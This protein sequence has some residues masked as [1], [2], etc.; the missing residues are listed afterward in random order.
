M[1]E[2]AALTVSLFLHHSLRLAL[3][4]AVALVAMGGCTSNPGGPS[5]GYYSVTSAS[6]EFYKYGP[7]Q[8]F[9]PDLL[10]KKGERL[11]ML[12]RQWGFSRVMMSNG[13]AGYVASE[14]I[15]P[16]IVSAASVRTASGSRR[17]PVPI[18]KPGRM[19]SSRQ[20]RIQSEI[21]GDP[22]DPLF[23]VN[24]VPLPLPDDVPAGGE[25]PSFRTTRQTPGE[26][27]A[28]TKPKF[29]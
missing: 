24:D 20:S 1:G 9:G 15:D 4:A 21:T 17:G 5:S 27:K 7:A 22:G 8:S 6:A 13:V 2:G 26:E 25:R 19:S 16:I 28:A 14:D 29:R 11:T 3:G 23:N 12:E 10:L 18:G